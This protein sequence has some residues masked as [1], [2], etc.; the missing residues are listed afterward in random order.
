M[1]A[2]LAT[3]LLAQTSSWSP[4][5]WKGQMTT[6]H[7]SDQDHVAKSEAVCVQRS[8]LRSHSP[9]LGTCLKNDSSRKPPYSGMAATGAVRSQDV[10]ACACALTVPFAGWFKRKPEGTRTILGGHSFD[11]YPFEI[12]HS[13]SA[14]SENV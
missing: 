9:C 2:A 12:H 6:E 5:M 3:S 10:A 7:L 14:S 1:V 11:T 8:T 13:R 4:S